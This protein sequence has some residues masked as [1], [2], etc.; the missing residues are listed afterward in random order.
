MKKEVIVFI[1]LFVLLA[2][3]M[4]IT[5]WISHPVEHLEQLASA[6]MPYHPL[7][8]TG[9]IYVAIGI[10]RLIITGIRYFWKRVKQ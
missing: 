7:L 4:H 1:A 3:G 8:Y 10:I 6:K 9:V 2:L 5:Q